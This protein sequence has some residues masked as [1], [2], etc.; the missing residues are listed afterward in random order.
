LIPLPNP[1]LSHR[2]LPLTDIFYLDECHDGD[3]GIADGEYTPEDANGLGV[4]HELGGVEVGGLQVLHLV[5][6]ASLLTTSAG[7]RK[8]FSPPLVKVGDKMYSHL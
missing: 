7:G 8:P 2:T 6:H 4:A 3:D 5:L 1:L